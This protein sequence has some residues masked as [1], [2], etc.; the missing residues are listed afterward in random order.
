[1]RFFFAIAIISLADSTEFPIPAR[2]AMK[3]LVHERNGGPGSTRQCQFF[4]DGHRMLILGS[5]S[6]VQMR[7]EAGFLMR[8]LRGSARWVRIA[9]LLVVFPLRVDEHHGEPSASG[10]YDEG[11]VIDF[12]S[13][14]GSGWNTA[15]RPPVFFSWHD[16]FSS[17]LA[18]CEEND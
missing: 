11:V 17:W 18:D 4:A 6:P 12:G 8:A 1:L 16:D 7:L 5:V 3:G 2:Q 14:I 9:L 13:F 15:I 10:A